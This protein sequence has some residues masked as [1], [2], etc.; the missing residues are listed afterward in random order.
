MSFKKKFEYKI[1]RKI[2]GL[3]LGDQKTSN[4]IYAAPY[5]EDAKFELEYEIQA[6]YPRKDP[7]D[8]NDINVL[9]YLAM[10]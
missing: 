8:T 7:E 3:E 1:F 5:L 2:H 10:V 4:L 9:D 6:Y